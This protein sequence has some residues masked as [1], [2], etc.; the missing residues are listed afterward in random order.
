MDFLTKL[1]RKFGRYALTNLT[2]YI[3]VTYVAGYL[4]YIINPSILQYITLEPY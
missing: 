1:E 4:L 3:I 2:Q